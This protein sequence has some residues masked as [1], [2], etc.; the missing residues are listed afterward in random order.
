MCKVHLA[1]LSL[2]CS[3]SCG[4]DSS[5][6]P[7]T[8]PVTE[9]PAGESADLKKTR[10]TPPKVTRLEP[11]N[12]VNDNTTSLIAAAPSQPLAQAGSPELRTT[13]ETGARPEPASA[14]APLPQGGLPAPMVPPIGVT[15]PVT[16]Q[17]T[18]PKCESSATIVAANQMSDFNWSGDG[19]LTFAIDS[20]NQPGDFGTIDILDADTVRYR[21][22][23]RIAT[24]LDIAVVAT[25]TTGIK[26]SCTVRLKADGALGVADDGRT[27]GL[28]G[29]VFQVPLAER[30]NSARIK[31]S[32]FSGAPLSSIVMPRIDVPNTPYEQGFPGYP[33]LTSWFAIRFRAQILIPESGYYGF[34]TQSD[35][36]SLLYIDGRVIVRNDTVHA[37][38]TVTNDQVYLEAGLHDIQLDYFQGPPIY[39][40]MSL[41]WRKPGDSQYMIIPATQFSRPKI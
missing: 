24:S 29:N 22:P 4:P 27:P 12:E 33:N 9:S 13:S 21:G 31:S 37:I 10:N 39:I 38:S 15:S 14:P 7:S 17:I 20:G 16:P 2:V 40:A 32:W 30:N 36:G 8:M 23:S 11:V 18:P 19:P 28:V 6:T 35:D 26:A 1:S 41:L 3:L 5:F 34:Q 25:N